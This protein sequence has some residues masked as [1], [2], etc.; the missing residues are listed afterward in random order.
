MHKT[1]SFNQDLG[2]TK[3]TTWSLTP[4]RPLARALP[5]G[6]TPRPVPPFGVRDP[7]FSASDVEANQFLFARNNMQASPVTVAYEYDAWTVLIP[8]IALWTPLIVLHLIA[9]FIA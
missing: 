2:P 3:T 7:L 1:I 9:A 8:L 6:V 5:K 4:V